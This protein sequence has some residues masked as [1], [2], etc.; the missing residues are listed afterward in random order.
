MTAIFSP[1]L[2]TLLLLSVTTTPYI[3]TSQT[4]S[5]NCIYLHKYC[6]NSLKNTPT[7]VRNAKQDSDHYYI[8]SSQTSSNF[9]S[10]PLEGTTVCHWE[11]IFFTLLSNYSNS[12]DIL[13]FCKEEVKSPSH[14]SLKL[15]NHLLIMSC[16]SI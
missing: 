13:E 8:R 4:L 10:M 9:S 14:A 2:L 11:V 12:I 3:S 16:S 15:T 1:P 6:T 7:S 5:L